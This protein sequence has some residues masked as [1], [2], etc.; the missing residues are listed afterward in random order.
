MYATSSKWNWKEQIKLDSAD[1]KVIKT[2]QPFDSHPSVFMSFSKSNQSKPDHNL[3]CHIKIFT[4]HDIFIS[5]NYMELMA[6]SLQKLKKF[7]TFASKELLF[8]K[9]RKNKI[10]SNRSSK[11]ALVE[12]PVLHSD[13]PW[14]YWDRLQETQKKQPTI[15]KRL[16]EQCKNNTSKANKYTY[17][18][19]MFYC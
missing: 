13:A 16:N 7:G 17:K 10:G 18:F 4:P 8:L 15:K 9:I 5:P 14:L 2:A 11:R 1:I 19:F 12:M 3:G 6:F